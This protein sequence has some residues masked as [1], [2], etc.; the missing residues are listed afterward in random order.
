MSWRLRPANRLAGA[1]SAR[2]L[3]VLRLLSGPQSL[4]D[5][6]QALYVSHETVK[7]HAKA[8]YHKLGVSSRTEAVA[9]GRRLGLLP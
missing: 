8:I 9:L 6:G 5:I 3:E 7:S 2:E 1:L 4:R